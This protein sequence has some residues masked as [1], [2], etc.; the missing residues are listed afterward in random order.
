MVL[1]LEQD[2]KEHCCG[3][4]FS[5]RLCTKNSKQNNEFCKR[6]ETVHPDS[7]QICCPQQDQRDTL[8]ILVPH[9]D[10]RIQRKKK[11][12]VGTEWAIPGNEG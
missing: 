3:L 6:V 11:N 5:K 9:G 10:K 4:E 7:C 1:Q 12:A 8:S 2:N